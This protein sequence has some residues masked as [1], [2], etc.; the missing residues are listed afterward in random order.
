MLACCMLRASTLTERSTVD[1]NIPIWSGHVA[2]IAMPSPWFLLFLLRP[3]SVTRAETPRLSLYPIVTTIAPCYH[4]I[5][6]RR[7]MSLLLLAIFPA[8]RA[9]ARCYS[10]DIVRTANGSWSANP[11]SMLIASPPTPS[12]RLSYCAFLPWLPLP[13]SPI[14]EMRYVCSRK[15]GA[16]VCLPSCERAALVALYVWP[17]TI[18]T[19]LGEA[20]SY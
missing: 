10:N 17:P 15:M 19:N 5:G 14:S 1:G 16:I 12:V 2:A 8:R 9:K 13:E 4:L 20:C 7:P 11:G 18:C 6:R 3:Y